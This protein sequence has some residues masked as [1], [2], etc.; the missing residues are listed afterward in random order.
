MKRILI[1]GGCGYIGTRL[2]DELSIDNKVDSMDTEWF[3]CSVRDN[4]PM[5][6]RYILPAMLATYDVVI[7]LA[8]HSSVKM[9]EKKSKDTMLNNFSNFIGLV[10]KLEALDKPVKFIYASSS[11][12]ASGYNGNGYSP[13]NAY[14]LSKF[15]IDT[16][17]E[18]YKKIDFY[19]LRF[20][21]LGGFSRN[22]RKELM[23]NSMVISSI[24]NG[25]FHVSGGMNN[26]PILGMSD[27]VR[28]IRV[29][30]ESGRHPGIYNL[31]SFNK[32]VNE[33]G[34]KVSEVMDVPIV[35]KDYPPSPYDF[36]IDCDKFCKT[37]NFTFTDTIESIA[38][39]LVDNYGTM[40]MG[41]RNTPREYNYGF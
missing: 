1:I 13:S 33:I 20:G 22:M 19:G 3:G 28:A 36:N 21:S 4:M 6:Y 41:D 31:A 40:S 30:V 2:Y 35:H 24:E 9:C 5:D 10:E 14:D 25:E 34:K 15:M 16:A 7:L 27:L 23:V 26:R 8:G 29:L 17:I 38:K 11:S 32:S 18:L 12:V 39:E 37:F